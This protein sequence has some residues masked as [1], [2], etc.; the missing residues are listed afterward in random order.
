MKKKGLLF[1]L[2][3]IIIILVLVAGLFIFLIQN[4]NP[5]KIFESKINTIF[6]LANT[7]RFSTAKGTIEITASMENDSEEMKQFKEIVDKTSIVSQSSIDTDN[8]LLNEIL[9]LKYD[10]EV[11]LNAE[12]LVQ[13][14]SIYV[15]V[16]DWLDKYLEIETEY[17]D[18]EEIK[19]EIE[20]A[21][22]IDTEKITEIIRQEIIKEIRK[23]KFT[24]EKTTL[25]IDGQEHNVKKTSLALNGEQLKTSGKEILTNLKQNEN[26]INALGEYKETFL[27]MTE[28]TMTDDVD[29]YSNM[30]FTIS[31]YTEG[32]LNKFI[33]ADVETQDTEEET[34]GVRITKQASNKY[35]FTTYNVTTEG[36]K[37]L[38]N[39]VMTNDMNKNS[40]KGTNQIIA[41]IPS[42]GK[43]GI[44]YAYNFEFGVDIEKINVDN[45]VKIDNLSQEDQ[46]TLMKNIE[47]SKIY[48]LISEI[49]G[50]GLTPYTEAN[51][52]ENEVENGDYTVSFNVPYNFE[53]MSNYSDQ[54]VYRDNASTET[55]NN[56]DDLTED[57]VNSLNK[58]P[59]TYI[60]VELREKTEEY[61]NSLDDKELH[62]NYFLMSEDGV[63]TDVS[64]MKT[65]PANGKDFMCKTISYTNESNDFGPDTVIMLYFYYPIDLKTEYLV[66]VETNGNISLEDIEQ[67][68]DIDI[69]TKT[70]NIMSQDF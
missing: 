33:A 13:D 62:N 38:F 12:V 10:N 26:F 60:T 1:I 4:S 22:T 23:Q 17:I 18:F 20:K 14:E 54:K 63:K 24:S 59:N 55:L 66:T 69:E 40:I 64:E 51:N 46:E 48:S 19:Q 50:S 28:N 27:R 15:A 11:L 57:F 68:L 67:F 58:S 16:K 30:I 25:S 70:K 45:S 2:I 43:V 53:Q 5:E 32:M 42:F 47:N 39:V 7:K 41:E 44:N 36:K 31:I 49:I 6:A 29:T 52:Q 3:P 8:L 21:K 35:L 34:Y 9:L 61:L 65:Y 56:D 37:D